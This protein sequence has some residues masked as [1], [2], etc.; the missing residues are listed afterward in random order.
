LATSLVDDRRLRALNDAGP[1]AGGHVLY[2]MQAAVRSRSN[3]ALEYAVQR[4]ND[5]GLP[6]LVVF[7]LWDDYPDATARTFHFLAQGLRDVAAALPRRAIGFEVHH[8]APLEVA[9][10]AAD[11]AAVVVTDRGHM[12]HAREWRQHLGAR[13]D[14]EAIEVETNLVVP[15][16]VVTDKRQ[17]AARTIRPRIHRHLDDFT[18][19]LLTTSV[20]VAWDGPTRGIDVSDPD[21]VVA[22]LDCDTSVP[23]VDRIAGGQRAAGRALRSF[24]DER[25]AGYAAGRNQPAAMQVSY[26]SPYLHFGQLSP[27]DAVLAARS[28][29]PPSEDLEAFVE[30]LVVRRE[31][32]HNYC[33]FE[34]AHDDWAALPEWARTTLDEHR[35]DEREVVYTRGELD[36]AATHDRAWNAA[37]VELRETGYMHNYMRMYWA[38]QILRWTNTPEYGFRVTR[39]LND[40]YLLDGRDPNSAVGVAWCYGLHDR[41]WQEREVF[42]KVRTMTRGGLERKFDVDAYVDLV[43]ELSGVDIAGD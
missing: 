39:A 16:D 33:W 5:L 6:L 24:V 31:L 22:A 14:V 4:A 15:V 42:G 1:G 19:E 12:R 41:A 35:D 27:V 37:Q 25:L 43:A 11:G 13:L 40:R 29:D 26:L 8:G 17:Y 18:V 10:A 23:P 30:E 34:D 32:A 21:R 36:R 7:G 9:L 20:D 28:V 3:P 38:K 2:W